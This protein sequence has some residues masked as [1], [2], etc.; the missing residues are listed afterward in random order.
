MLLFTYRRTHH[1]APRELM[2]VIV[3]GVE[4]EV[5]DAHAHVL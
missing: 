4:L 5:G 2:Y 3:F 1:K